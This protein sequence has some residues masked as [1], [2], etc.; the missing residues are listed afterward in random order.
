MTAPTGALRWLRVAVLALL[1][2]CSP[3]AYAQDA[4]PI[5]AA[6]ADLKFAIEEAAERFHA[7]TGRSVKISTGSS[8]NFY[9]QLLQGA[10]FQLFMSADEDYV[11]RLAE[12]GKARDRGALYAIGRI[13]LFVPNGSTLKVDGSLVDLQAAVA[14]G[15]IQKF[16]IANP[17]HAPY[18]A[19]AQEALQAA[20]VWDAIKP[21]LVLGENVSQAAQFASGGSTQGGIF[22]YSLAVAPAMSKLGAYALIP[23][24]L[25][26]PLRQRMV[27]IK[28]ANETAVMFYDYL[29]QPTARSIFKRYG[30]VR[31]GEL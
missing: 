31:P 16:A 26:R 20:N 27:L 21:K 4:P 15:R 14:D 29:Q 3:F 30:F 5:V 24:T 12:T 8:G 22:A 6:A 7:E 19:R 23:E 25:H 10:P 28:G 2:F 18:G 13:V 11:F 17:E 1:P 9:Q